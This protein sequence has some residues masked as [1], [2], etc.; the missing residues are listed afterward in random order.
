[1]P[2]HLSTPPFFQSLAKYD[3]IL[4]AG[5][6]GGFDIFSGIPLFLALREMG[7]KV[8]L[9]SLTFADFRAIKAKKIASV[10]KKVNAD[11]EG[12][13]YFPEGILAEWLK[14]RGM[15]QP[16]FTFQRCGGRALAAAYKQL[17]AELDFQAIVLVDGGTDSL[18]FGRKSGLGTPEEDMLSIG[19]VFEVGGEHTYLASLGFGVDAFHGV[20]HSDFL[21]NT[22]LLSQ[23]EAFL[24]TLTLLKNMSEAR[25]FLHAV[26][27]ANRVYPERASIVCN[28]IASAIM[29]N[30]GDYHATKRTLG[31]ELYINPLM[32]TYFFYRLPALAQKIEFLPQI[33]ATRSF[34]E[35]GQVIND[36]RAMVETRPRR[37][38]PL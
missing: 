34:E 37:Q 12:P 15:E 14:S 16:V 29:G 31:T 24:G 33:Q 5:T 20:S 2:F 22:A 19:A 18:M 35:V 9:A 7:K 26:S 3:R 21:E 23:E 13:K 4:I 17:K 30:F 28:S 11:S 1:M 27:F 36:F 10:C 38:I 6:G 25:E 32:A 8:H